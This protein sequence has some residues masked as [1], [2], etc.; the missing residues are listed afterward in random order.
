M[1]QQ[2]EELIMLLH[3]AINEFHNID[4]YFRWWLAFAAGFAFCLTALVI[5]SG[6]LTYSDWTPNSFVSVCLAVVFSFSV[7][8]FLLLP[9]S[10][11]L[12][13]TITNIIEIWQQRFQKDAVWN[14]ETFAQEYKAV[15]NLR[16]ADGSLLENFDKHPPPSPGQ[17]EHYTIPASTIT[18]QEAI[19][20]IDSRRVAGHFYKHFP[21]LSN[22]LGTSEQPI[23][24]VLRNDMTE[25][26]RTNP[27]TSYNHEKSVQLAGAEMRSLLERK[28][29]RIIF[30]TRAL[31][32]ALLIVLWLPLYAWAIYDAWKKLEPITY[33]L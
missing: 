17:N 20:D 15:H 14:S 19:A 13:P 7:F 24:D 11:Y 3:G 12:K 6:R 21:L 32:I 4:V 29:S 5:L 23:P 33:R 9:A 26:F 16:K 2:L 8:L 31:I 1:F 28:I 30:T 22:L 10:T 18:A 27:G 25:F